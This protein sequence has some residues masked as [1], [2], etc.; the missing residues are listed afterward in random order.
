MPKVPS[1]SMAPSQQTSTPKLLI[2]PVNPPLQQQLA[3]KKASSLATT[4]LADL[5]HPVGILMGTSRRHQA[6]L[7]KAVL[8]ISTDKSPVPQPQEQSPM[9]VAMPSPV[10]MLSTQTMLASKVETSK[11]LVV[12]LLALISTKLSLSPTLIS[13]EPSYPHTTLM[14]STHMATLTLPPL[15]FK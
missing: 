1:R 11:P 14:P 6:L 2:Q 12:K 15:L 4:L 5:P 8:L 10:P 7:S 3:S 9:V 13:T